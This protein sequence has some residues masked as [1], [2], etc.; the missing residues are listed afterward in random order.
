VYIINMQENEQ[1]RLGL[2]N[3]AQ[4]STNNTVL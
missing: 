4:I 1:V 2:A 3:C